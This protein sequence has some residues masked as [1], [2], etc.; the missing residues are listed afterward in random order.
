[1]LYVIENVKTMYLIG[2]LNIFKLIKGNF[3]IIN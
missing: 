3:N 2:K 1:M